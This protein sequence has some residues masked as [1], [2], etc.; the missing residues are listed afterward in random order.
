MAALAEAR[1]VTRRF[2]DHVAVERASLEV[3]EGEIVGLI[4]ANGAGKT[5]LIRLL[6]GLLVPTSGATALFGRPPT[7]R[8]RT[9]LGYVSQGLGLYSDM[10][11]AENVRFITAS[12]GIGADAVVMPSDLAN[13]GDTLV[14]RIGLGH[15][16]QLAF[17][18][19][20]A[21]RPE[22]LV[23][24]EPTSGV[25]PLARARLWDRIHEQAESSVG[26]LVTTHYLQEAQQ[27]D[28]LVLMAAGR[29]VATGALDQIISG[30]RAAQV[31]TTSWSA[32][33]NALDAAGCAVT[34]A[35]TRVRVADRSPGEVRRVLD[36]AQI[37]ADVEDVPATL[38]ETMTLIDRAT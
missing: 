27:C 24:D 14:G 31:E 32:A 12:F 26:V 17:A 4:G 15:Q 11:V 1:A 13:L 21:H 25:N 36:A 34:L 20:I 35:G 38:E 23:L 2:G 29:I 28:R 19:A 9:R 37:D 8:G 7:R 16:R 18:C 3:D 6:L 5:T 33:F 30:R 22:L 10:T